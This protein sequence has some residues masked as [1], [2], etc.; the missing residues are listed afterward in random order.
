[1]AVSTLAN[2]Y[3]MNK[4]ILVIDGHEVQLASAGLGFDPNA[5][6]ITR[7]VYGNVDSV[8]IF[9][10]V[11]GP[12]SVDIVD[13]ASLP[14]VNKI[15]SGFDPATTG[16]IVTRGNNPR[17]LL[18]IVN[19]MDD[20]RSGYDDG[21]E[22]LKNWAARFGAP[23]GDPDGLA[24]RTLQGNADVPR[25]LVGGPQWLFKRVA[26]TSTGGGLTGSWA[27]PTPVELTTIATGQYALYLEVQ[28]GSGASFDSAEI[29]VDTTNVAISD[30]GGQVVIPHADAINAG[31]TPATYAYAIIGHSTTTKV[32]HDSRYGAT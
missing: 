6:E 13:D 23:K 5:N 1:M 21:S 8:Q 15:L 24:V 26:L 31:I 27:T 12:Q 4:K 18:A 9:Q 25:E 16:G 22:A 19:T 17:K 3:Q 29:K 7:P 28:K 20:A 10:Y 11:S 32:T 30:S 14:T 2:A